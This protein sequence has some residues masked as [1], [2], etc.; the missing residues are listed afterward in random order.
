MGIVALVEVLDQ[1]EDVFISAVLTCPAKRRIGQR[2]IGMTLR[3]TSVEVLMIPFS[4]AGQGFHLRFCYCFCTLHIFA[5]RLGALEIYG[6]V[7]D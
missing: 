2:T 3:R 7:V 5:A 1:T 4:L 6:L